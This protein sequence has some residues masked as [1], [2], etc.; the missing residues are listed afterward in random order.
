MPVFRLQGRLILKMR[1][2]K[3][4][5]VLIPRRERGPALN[6]GVRACFGSRRRKVILK[7]YFALEKFDRN[8]PVTEK[9]DR[10]CRNTASAWT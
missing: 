3:I 1:I 6:S 5:V 9:N 2:L 8:V 10:T 7:K 4:D